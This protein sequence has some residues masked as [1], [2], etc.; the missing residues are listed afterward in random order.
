M[1]VHTAS[2]QRFSK[3]PEQMNTVEL[4]AKREWLKRCTKEKRIS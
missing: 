3:A 1:L 2:M 4:L